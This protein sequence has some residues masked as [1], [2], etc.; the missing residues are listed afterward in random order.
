VIKKLLVD[1]KLDFKICRG[2]GYDN[3]SNMRGKNKGVQ[4]RIRQ[5]NPRAF[6]M[7]CGSLSLNLVVGESAIS[8]TEAVSFFGIIQHI[9][10]LFSA[11]GGRWK[12]LKDSAPILSNHFATHVGNAGLIV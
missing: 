7:P 2:Q 12:I 9:Y 8:S 1:S 6:F 4:A 10:I 11:S 3:G 5:E